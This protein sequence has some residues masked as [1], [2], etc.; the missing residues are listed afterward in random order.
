MSQGHTR[1]RRQRQPGVPAWWTDSSGSDRHVNQRFEVGQ[2]T[3]SLV[4][5][6][7]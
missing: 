5:L 6:Q 1:R 4:H 7:S 2:P 3:G